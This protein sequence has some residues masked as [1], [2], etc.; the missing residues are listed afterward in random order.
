MIWG[1][2]YFWKHPFRDVGS[3]DYL[4]LAIQHGVPLLPVYAF[5]E[6][7]LFR[8]DRV[9][10]PLASPVA[11][12]VGG[13]SRLTLAFQKSGQRTGFDASIDGSTRNFEENGEG[14]GN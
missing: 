6:N 8:M 1:Y 3:F 9:G 10:S 4:R 5:G 2:P 12:V 14:K 7:Q 13:F 11:V